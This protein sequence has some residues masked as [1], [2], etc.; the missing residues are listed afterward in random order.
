MKPTALTQRTFQNYDQEDYIL[1][2]VDSFLV[3]RRARGLAAGSLRFYSQKLKLFTDFCEGQAVTQIRQVDA[4]LLRRLLIWLEETGHNPGGVHGCYRAVKAFLRWWEDEIEPEGWRNPIRKVK[5]PKVPDDP[6]EPVEIETVRLMVDACKGSRLTDA[7]DRAILLTLLD[8]GVRANELRMIDLDD[9]DL[10]SGSILVRQGK[11]RKPRMVYLSQKSR[12]AIRAYLK[13]RR[14]KDPALW[15]TDEGGRL[16]YD[17]LR[18]IL[19]RR[20]NMAGVEPP[21]LHDFR[22]AFAINLLRAGVDIFAVQRLMGH[23]NLATLRRYLA[24]TDQDARAAHAKG[25]PVDRLGKH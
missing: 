3:D 2:W 5:P 23:T 22:R 15:V 16:S 20:A 10:A 21:S 14:D 24:L 19:T 4:N 17:G 25:S 7:R 13:I 8:T 12:K 9:L 11:G 6:L 1:V 18:G